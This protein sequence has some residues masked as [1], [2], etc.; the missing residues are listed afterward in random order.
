MKAPASNRL[1]GADELILI[2]FSLCGS[3][4]PVRGGIPLPVP[5]DFVAVLLNIFA[6]V[7]N[8]KHIPDGC[9]GKRFA[10]AKAWLP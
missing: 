4:R 9:D 5:A 1:R 10:G 2:I 8:R 6:S 7:R 3:L